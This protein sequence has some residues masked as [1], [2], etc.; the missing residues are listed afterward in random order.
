LGRYGNTATDKLENTFFALCDYNMFVN[1]N[2]YA[3][4]YF[5]IREYNQKYQRQGDIPYPISTKNKH[6][7]RELKEELDNFSKIESNQTH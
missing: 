3:K 7:T 2:L 4:Y 5:Q 6:Y 1:A